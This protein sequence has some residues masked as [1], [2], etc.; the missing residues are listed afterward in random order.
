MAL[1]GLLRAQLYRLGVSNGD[2]VFVWYR[3]GNFTW[4]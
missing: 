2:G 4:F 3:N 1:M